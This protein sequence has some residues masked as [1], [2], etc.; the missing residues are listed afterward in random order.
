MSADLRHTVESAL[1]GVDERGAFRPEDV[2]LLRD[3]VEGRATEARLPDHPAEVLGSWE[4]L[5]L[6]ARSALRRVAEAE[7]TR[8]MD[9]YPRGRMWP[10]LVASYFTAEEILKRRKALP[11]VVANGGRWASRAWYGPVRLRERLYGLRRRQ[12]WKSGRDVTVADLLEALGRRPRW[13]LGDYAT[14]VRVDPR[15]RG[16]YWNRN[17]NVAFGYLIGIDL[18]PSPDG[19]WCV[20]ANLNTAFN[21]QRRDVLDPEPAVET[22]FSTA[23]EMG[24]RH[25]RW[26]D[27]DRSE[28][29]LWLMEELREAAH[30]SGM[31]LDI[32]ESY[33]IP[34]RNDLPAGTSRPGKYVTSP[35][36]LPD[37]TLVLRRNKYEVGSDFVV[38]NKGPFIRAVH[39]ELSRRGNSRARVPVM[40]ADPAAVFR[41][42]EAGLPNLVYKYPDSGKGQGVY[43]LRV[44]EPGRARDIAREIDRKSGEPPGL[45]QP[46]VCSRVL[47]GRRIYDVRCELF[48][49]PMG[50]RHVFSIRREATQSLPD[51]LGEGLVKGEGV[52]TSNLATGGRFAPLDPEEEEELRSAALA[53]GEA[54]IGALNQTFE[55]IE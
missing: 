22:L 15:C 3:A 33:L 35:V 47:P 49:T 28:T 31:T 19:V 12:A 29:R 53:I 11:R 16:F 2:P 48:I 30:A 34:R 50:A 14:G 7:I 36:D 42:G 17:R 27:M 41:N 9:F 52:F 40:S 26:Y 10:S 21:Q 1:R 39:G 23:R 8:V 6:P 20:E 55:T 43:F 54:L 5:P 13:L 44:N 25:V 46:F 32:R 37:D 4:T 24:A 51:T 45:F 38:S 18:I